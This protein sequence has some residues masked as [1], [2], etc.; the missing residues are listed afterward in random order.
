MA[1]LGARFRLA[2]W[3]GPLEARAEQGVDLRSPE[4]SFLGSHINRID[5]KGRIAAPA[6]FRRALEGDPIRGFYAFRSLRGPFL[7]CGGGDLITSFK[8]LILEKKPGADD[9]DAIEAHVYGDIRP[10]AFDTEGRVVIPDHF[11]KHA[12]FA[13]RVLFQGRGDTFLMMAAEG[14][15][16]RFAATRARA[17]EALRRLREPKVGS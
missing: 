6:D 10:L 17:S 7:E 2:S 4:T 3:R 9:L 15:E 12:E 13:E 11:R 8:A 16:E 1:P 5:Q 14:A